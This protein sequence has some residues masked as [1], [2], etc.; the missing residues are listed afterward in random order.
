MES[1]QKL[2]AR[3]IPQILESLSGGPRTTVTVHLASGGCLTGMILDIAEPRSLR[4]TLLLHLTDRHA[5]TD[6]LAYLPISGISALVVHDAG[7]RLEQL[8]SGEI[9]SRQDSPPPTRLELK[10]QIAEWNRTDQ[11]HEPR[12][13]WTVDWES[14][15]EGEVVLQQLAIWLDELRQAMAELRDEYGAGFIPSGTDLSLQ[16]THSREPSLEIQ[17][18][19]LG[20][21]ADFTRGTAGHPAPGGL[22]KTIAAL[23]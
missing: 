8:S 4:G 3:P 9:P 5:A 22:K 16:V 23:L 12:Q 14:L 7:P 18:Q 6:D 13:T 19:V 20:F 2:N 15:P 21:Q 11:E 1:F 10:R 17:N